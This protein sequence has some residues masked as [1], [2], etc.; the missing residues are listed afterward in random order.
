MT[1]K[2]TGALACAIALAA[3]AA[4]AAQADSFGTCDRAVQVLHKSG[5]YE[6]FEQMMVHMGDEIPFVVGTTCSVTP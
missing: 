5:F 6:N 3:A 2:L 1:K 4:P